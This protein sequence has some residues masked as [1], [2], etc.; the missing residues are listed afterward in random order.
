LP[1][2]KS[3]LR[4]RA[5][6]A[7][8][9]DFC[10]LGGLSMEKPTFNR[11]PLA[12]GVAL[13]IGASTMSPALA[14][15]SG[16]DVIEEITVT[17]IR[18]SQMD[19][20]NMKRDSESIVDGIAATDLGKLPDVTVADSLQRIPGIQIQRNAG[21]GATVNI[22]GLPQ[23]RT[24]L[25]GEQFLTAGNIG[26]AQPNLTDI[27]SQLINGVNV[28]KSTNLKN[29]RSGLTGT[30]DLRTWRPLDFDEGFTTQI[31]AEYANG[32]DTSEGDTNINGLINWN[33]GTVGFMVSAVTSE[34]N[35]G[36]NFAGPGG[37]IL[38]S[39]DWGEIGGGG[40]AEWIAPHGFESHNRVVERQ[41]DGIN[42][43]FQAEFG[44]GFTL[45]AETFYTEMEEYDRKVGINISN[46]WTTLNWLT[47][48]EFTDTGTIRNNWS[49]G[50]WISSQQYDVDALWINS[51]T[52]N[53][54]ATSDS[55][56][57]NLELKY[58]A[59]NWSVRGRY[60]KDSA[61]RLS[62]NGQ[63]QGDLS[64]WKGTQRFA[65]PAGGVPFYPTEICAMYDPSR[66][67]VAG[68]EG[69]CFIDPNPLGYGEDP[70]LHVD[71]SNGITEWSGF[72]TPI[73]GG[74]GDGATLADYMAN[75]DSYAIGAFSS[76]GNNE[77]AADNEIF[78]LDGSY[79]FDAPVGGFLTEVTGGVRSSKREGYIR[80]FHL[81]SNFYP[82]ST[83]TD[84]MG[85]LPA[86]ANGCAA[87]WKAIDVAMNWPNE[88]QAGEFVNGAFQPYTVN[89]PTRVDEFNNVV[90]VS[91]Y[92]SNTVGLPGV[93]AADPRDYDDVAAF[94]TRVF[95]A[96]NRVSI[97][98]TSYDV[99]LDEISYFV[100]TSFAFEDLNLS[101]TLGFRYIDTEISTR[102][103]TVEPTPLPYGD[104]Q[105][106]T[107]DLFTKNDYTDFLPA[108]NLNYRPTDEWTVR[109]SYSENMIAHDLGTY[110]GGLQIT[111]VACE[112]QTIV[113]GR[114]VSGANLLG[115]P[116]LDPWRTTNYDLSAEYYYGD[117]SMFSFGVF[118]VDIESFTTTTSRDAQY[119]DSD[120][121]IR[122]TVQETYTEL[123]QGGSIEGIETGAKLAFADFTTS[124]FWADFG[125]DANYTYAPSDAND[126]DPSG[127]AK[128]FQDNSE[129]QY[130]LVGW[131]QNENWEARV[132]WNWRSERYT[133]DQAG[134]PGYQDS[135]G[136]LDAQATYHINDDVSVYVNGSNMTGES[137]EY[138]LD[139]GAGPVQYWQQNEFEARYTI[140]VRA[141][142]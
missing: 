38:P 67:T 35:L 41:R 19:A 60:I 40:T 140:G 63:S 45:T 17:G 98:A 87:Q 89:R 30:I 100:D 27:P 48:T 133:G 95:G 13:A 23:V 2:T 6:N 135:I 11:N 47:P 97:P 54:T 131:F 138:Y 18:K 22:R 120:G 106:D 105:R 20:V 108:L 99:T 118:Y 39:N 76:E 37:S 10:K 78:S 43:A 5:S 71:F 80:N 103:N 122:R 82:G 128:P 123:G 127:A 110:G 65:L 36:N 142:F 141:R 15:D 121:V 55:L 125:L 115:N 104:T 57:N 3:D 119:P 129:H 139:W 111:T 7:R 101:G 24:L 86:G 59:E 77:N 46:R 74:L 12:V 26:T 109:F 116:L 137:E 112:D 91:D 117:E 64:N 53:R 72:D 83:A 32:Q 14:Q 85:G 84:G 88:C 81:F 107:G 33:N 51:F 28:Y 42:A 94:H 9:G 90:F 92:G 114:C 16:D 73:S 58:D 130:N 62:T 136:Y 50:N 68:D 1:E 21:E 75:V 93:W 134:V 29:K 4:I 44:D 69:G 25:N 79:F 34:A 61:D 31:A 70:Q 52:V 132:A 126:T 56:H 124:D 49:G 113:G 8:N 66:V 96:A 102:Q